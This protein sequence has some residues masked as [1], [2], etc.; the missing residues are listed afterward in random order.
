MHA[1]CIY[2]CR[3]TTHACM[4]IYSHTAR[5]ACERSVRERGDS[6]RGASCVQLQFR[7]V[8]LFSDKPSHFV[9]SP[10]VVANLRIIMMRSLVQEH[11]EDRRERIDDIL[12]TYELGG[13]VLVSPRRPLCAFCWCAVM[14]PE[15]AQF[16][17]QNDRADPGMLA[18]LAD[19]GLTMEDVCCGSCAISGLHRAHS[20]NP[21]ADWYHGRRCVGGGLTK[22][23]KP[24]K[25]LGDAR[26]WPSHEYV[27]RPRNHWPIFIR[28][29]RMPMR[30][31]QLRMIAER[32]VL[33]GNLLAAT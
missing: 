24:P 7:C 1:H 31:N 6:I 33:V 19:I 30:T 12:F 15:D 28:T 29:T 9:H 2:F 26:R 3:R 11:I 13:A 4:H 22:E 20:A 27:H 10:Y 23:R 14:R 8:I 17:V 32:P 16:A 25:K 18:A 21:R 5:C